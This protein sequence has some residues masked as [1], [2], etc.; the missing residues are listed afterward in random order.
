MAPEDDPGQSISTLLRDL[1][2]VRM[3]LDQA[4]EWLRDGKKSVGAAALAEK[5]KHLCQLCAN[6]DDPNHLRELLEEAEECLRDLEILLGV[7]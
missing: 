5:T 7:H 6:C 4:Q 3:R 2:A 1:D